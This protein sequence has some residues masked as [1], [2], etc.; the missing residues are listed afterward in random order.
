M[1]NKKP[2]VFSSEQTLK[3]IRLFTYYNFTFLDLILPLFSWKSSCQAAVYLCRIQLRK[4]LEGRKRYFSDRSESFAAPHIF[5]VSASSA[6][7]FSV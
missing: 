6:P 4:G 7:S 1:K 2:Y 3:D 5:I